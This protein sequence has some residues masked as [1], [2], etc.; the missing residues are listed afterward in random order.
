MKTE[1]RECK[2]CGQTE[3]DHLGFIPT[4]TISDGD[5][6]LWVNAVMCTSCGSVSEVPCDDEDVNRAGDKIIMRMFKNN[7][8]TKEEFDELWEE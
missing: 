5:S 1:T 8:I 3:H 6:N 7:I 2:T 4:E